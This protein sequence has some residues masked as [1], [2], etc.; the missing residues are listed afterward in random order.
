MPGLFALVQQAIAG[1]EATVTY[2]PVTGVPIALRSD[3]VKNGVDDEFGFTV[4]DWSLAPPDDG[5]LGRVTTARTRWSSGGIAS[6][7]LRVR[8]GCECAVAATYAVRVQD[9]DLR[10]ATSDGEKLDED[11][12]PELPITVD[13]IFDVAASYATNGHGDLA[14]DPDLGYLRRVAAD[15]DPTTTGD[16]ETIEV[17]DFT[18]G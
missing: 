5:P 11:V 9:G 6:Y 16:E 17:L 3:P 1:D 12:I 15:P 2:D 10:E 4:D 13:R 14:F 8:I 18:P 7:R